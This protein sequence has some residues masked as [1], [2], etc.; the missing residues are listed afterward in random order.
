[1]SITFNVGALT[2]YAEDDFKDLRENSSPV[3]DFDAYQTCA[4]YLLLPFPTKDQVEVITLT[5]LLFQEL[6]MDSIRPST[7]RAKSN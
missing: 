6:P 3:K 2:P 1:M 7:C 4:N 5:T